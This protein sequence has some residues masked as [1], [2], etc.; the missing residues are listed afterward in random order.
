MLAINGEMSRFEC[1]G[2]KAEKNV[3]S[4]MDDE[5]RGLIQELADRISGLDINSS[6]QAVVATY[7]RIELLKAKIA[8]YK[9]LLAEH[10]ITLTQ[11]L[12]ATTQELTAKLSAS[13]PTV[14]PTEDSVP[15]RR[16]VEAD[17]AEW[18]SLLDGIV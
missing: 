13:L 18:S 7:Q 8:A 15:V 5:F 6:T 4:A 3:A 2:A 9:D 16:T 12:T 11:S 10:T 14:L 17:Q 1:G